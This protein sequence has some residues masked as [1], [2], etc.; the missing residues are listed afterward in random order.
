MD[1]VIDF[2]NRLNLPLLLASR[3]IQFKYRKKG[4]PLEIVETQPKYS[5]AEYLSQEFSAT[6]KIAIIKLPFD[7][8]VQNTAWRLD[9]HGDYRDNLL[10]SQRKFLLGKDWDQGISSFCLCFCLKNPYIGKA[11][12]CVFTLILK[13]SML[14]LWTMS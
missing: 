2:L 14:H 4:L 9:F 12:I 5:K 3:A 6:Y 8:T 10:Q 13:S 11:L 1:I 7:E